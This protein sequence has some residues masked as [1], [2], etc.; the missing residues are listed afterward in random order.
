MT[1]EFQTVPPVASERNWGKRVRC[2][3]GS[4]VKLED[5]RGG[6][7]IESQCSKFLVKA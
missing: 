7:Q 6:E 1:E 4:K 2:I 5:G 3:K